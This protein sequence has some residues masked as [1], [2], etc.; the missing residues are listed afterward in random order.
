MGVTTYVLIVDDDEMMCRTLS[1]VLEKMSYDVSSAASGEDALHLLEE[2]FFDLILL[3]IKL[4]DMSGVEVLSRIKELDHDPFV[5]VMTAYA[6]VET[7]VAAMKAGAYDYVNKPFDIDELRLAIKKAM[8]TKA[9]KGE[10][11]RLRHSHRDVDG[12]DQICGESPQ[13]DVVRELIALVS[14]TP[15][16]PVLV[17]GESGTGKELVANAIHME[18]QR[19]ERPIIR[20]N[21]SAIPETLMEAELF[22]H[23]KGAFTDAKEARPGLI[24]LAQGGTVLLDEISEMKL[25][26]QP[27]LLRFLETYTLMRVGGTRDIKV[28]VRIVASTNKDLAQLVE[29]GKFRKDLYYRIKVMV[30]ELPPLRD[31]REDIPL[32]VE[33]FL[34]TLRRELGK[35]IGAVSEDALNL[36]V[37]YQWPGNVRELKNVLERAAI[38]ARGGE[39]G[40]EDLPLELRHGVRGTSRDVLPLQIMA[41][42]DRHPP[43]ADV[44]QNYIIKVLEDFN[45]NKSETARVLGISRSTLRE[46]LMRYGIQSHKVKDQVKKCPISVSQIA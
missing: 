28:D 2:R 26:L 21:C 40:A 14:Q 30:I 46:K 38:L 36:L 44:E 32:L 18:S 39:I 24:E 17:Q 41:H 25:S 12:N 1:E 9:L 43:L 3:D 34:R 19:R 42:G 11:L 6:E 31:R 4:P 37:A 22:G 20:I 29:Q 35:G 7:A 5:I 33:Y 15:R 10:V 16:T 45:Y 23:E 27:K 13:M 8:E